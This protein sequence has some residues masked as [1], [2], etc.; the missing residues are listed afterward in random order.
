MFRAH[1]FGQNRSQEKDFMREE[2]GIASLELFLDST[3][4]SGRRLSVS[5]RT[6]ADFANEV[7]LYGVVEFWSKL[8][9]TRREFSVEAFDTRPR[10]TRSGLSSR[11]GI[12]RGT[13]GG[14][15]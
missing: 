15:A 5:S 4:G 7:F 3:S 10:F 8:Y 14:H 9:P 1:L 11:R 6:E 12:C 2:F 13:I